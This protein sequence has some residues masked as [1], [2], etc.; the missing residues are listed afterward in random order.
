MSGC[1]SEI[2][3]IPPLAQTI[4]VNDSPIGVQNGVNNY[5]TTPYPF[6][7]NTLEIYIDGVK[8][9]KSAYVADITNQGFSFII[10]P[11]DPKKLNAPVADIE[12]LTINYFR[13]LSG[14]GG[15]L[16]L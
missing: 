1:I 11:T 14:G 12:T 4:V 5:F 3:Y 13:D 7:E 8:V 6:I 9:D 15:F 16:T 10:D 2:P